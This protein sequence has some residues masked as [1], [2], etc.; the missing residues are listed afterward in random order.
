MKKR[1]SPITKDI[2]KMLLKLGILAFSMTTPFPA[3]ALLVLCFNEKYPR[4]KF[5]TYFCNLKK[6]K[7]I[8]VKKGKNKMYIS[9]TKKGRKE[10]AWINIADLAIMR[11]LRWDGKWRIVMF[12]IPE[13]LRRIRNLLR[14]KL[15]Q[16]GFYQLQ[17]SVWIFPYDCLKEID[18]LRSFF[19]LT[20]RRLILLTTKDLFNEDYFKRIFNLK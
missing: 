13:N 1:T 4:E 2:L 11:P 9:L 3:I 14:L 16:F 17:E 19:N 20:P 7:F 10:V 8:T 6:N 18:Q 15:K 5:S 12:D